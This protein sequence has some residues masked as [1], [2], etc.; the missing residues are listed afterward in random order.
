[1]LLV[2]LGA[3]GVVVVSVTA[4]LPAGAVASLAAL[5]VGG[6][7]AFG[8]RSDRWWGLLALGLGILRGLLA[9]EPATVPDGS[10]MVR[11]VVWEVQCSAPG[12]CNLRLV[13]VT[14]EPEGGDPEVRLSRTTVLGL[15]LE[16][17][18]PLGSVVSFPALAVTTHSASNPASDWA[19]PRDRLR[20][21]ATGPLVE[22]PGARAPWSAAL[23][24]R[25]HDRLELSDPRAAGLYRALLLGDRGSVPERVRWAFQDTGTAHLLAISGLH[26][27][28]VAYG[29]YRLVLL[30]LLLAVP[31]VAQAGRPPAVAAVIALG[32]LWLYGGLVA[33]SD[34][35]ARA[36]LVATLALAGAIL[37]RRVTPRRLLGLAF[38]SA[39]LVDPEAILRPS[40]QLSFSAA[41]S[42]VFGAPLLR[43]AKA[44]WEEP[45]RVDNTFA[46][47]VLIALTTLSLVNLLTHV[48][49]APLTVAWF[50]QLAHHGLWVNLFAV[51]LMGLVVLPVGIF[52]SVLAFLSPT[53]A[54]SLAEVPSAVG[55]TF[56]GL[57]EGAS[58]VSGASTVA[59]LPVSL[60]LPMILSL[61]A[62]LVG[63][64]LRVP[65]LAGLGLC[66]IASLALGSGP[67]RGELRLTALDVGHGDALVLQLPDGGAALVDAGG[68]WGRGDANARL[69]G[70]TLAPALGQ[71]GVDALDVLIISHADRDHIGGALPLVERVPVRELWLPPCSASDPRGRALAE[72]VVARG[73]VVRLLHRHRPVAWRGVE[74]EILW[75]REDAL[76]LDGE[77]RL[78]SNDA[79][80]VLAL[81]YAGRSLLLTGDIEADAEAALVAEVGDA[82]AGDVL[83][84][85]HHGSRTSSTGPFLDLV[86]ASVVVVPG[87][88]GRGNMPPHEDVLDDYARRGAEVW[89]TGVHGAVTVAIDRRGQIR[90]TSSASPPPAAAR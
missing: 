5:V 17:R 33:P 86:G 69:A 66:L 47:R 77:C 38:A 87:A 25:L 51:P 45:G 23:G 65:G 88:P 52:W 49:T 48:A 24:A 27:A 43:A 28:M 13:D 11:G 62:V 60:A 19:R 67:S 36:L 79:S 8:A 56:V 31:R 53:L 10:V 64:R 83:K 73:G 32:G 90:V 7:L 3:L 89:I 74:L 34:A 50:G 75:P 18:P 72:A 78:S 85:P 12:R 21:R 1:M 9:G 59:S 40:F 71:L 2:M 46:R 26:V 42:L 30:F 35:T 84:S 16:D 63:G 20:L 57:I 54:A 68:V 55:G 22:A 61:L 14:V 39:L 6:L 81:R 76:R 15:D 58:A 44:W 70:R 4:I 80:L 82:L 41:A 29:L 37:A